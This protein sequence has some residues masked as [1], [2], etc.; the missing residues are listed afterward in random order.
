MIFVA[1]YA[2]KS[3]KEAKLIAVSIDPGLIK[4][5]VAKMITEQATEWDDPAIEK[6]E[7]GRT[8]ALKHILEKMS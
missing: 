5:V 7:E 1:L 8:N 3:T 2:G 4:E 6:L